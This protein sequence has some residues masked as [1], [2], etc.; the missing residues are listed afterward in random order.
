[1]KFYYELVNQP[2][3]LINTRTVEIFNS[4][5]P[6]QMYML[7]QLV[8]Y[9]SFSVVGL[10][11][12]HYSCFIQSRFAL[13]DTGIL[14]HLL[15]SFSQPKPPFLLHEGHPL[16]SPSSSFGPHLVF[17]LLEHSLISCWLTDASKMV[18]DILSSIWMLSAGGLTTYSLLYLL[19]IE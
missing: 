5:L 8:I 17:G 14:H 7:S 13:S 10:T 16:K 6:F 9:F 1:M 12:C 11:I 18:S 15:Q 4:N 3:K 19:E 2:P